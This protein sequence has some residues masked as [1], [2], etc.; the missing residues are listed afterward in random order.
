MPAC[1]FFALKYGFVIPMASFAVVDRPLAIGF[2]EYVALSGH[3]TIE[4][5]RLWRN[6]LCV[7]LVAEFIPRQ[8]LIL[9][10][11]PRF[12][13]TRAGTADRNWV[14][15]PTCPNAGAIVPASTSNGLST[16]KALNGDFSLPGRS[17]LIGAGVPRGAKKRPPVTA[18]LG[19]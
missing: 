7:K 19:I 3:P 9:S 8:G 14:P 5:V 4:A 10:M 2:I 12:K 1:L 17:A 18:P 16:R 13:R 15:N 6:T 11:M